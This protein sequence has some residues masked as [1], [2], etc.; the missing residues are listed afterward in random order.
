[1]KKIILIATI[2][3]S[4]LAFGQADLERVQDQSIKTATEQKCSISL[5]YIG[6]YMGW[7]PRGSVVTDVRVSHPFANSSPFVYVNCAQL[8]IVCT[9]KE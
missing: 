5:R 3:V 4:C 1:M 7:C 6:R 2:L 8:K 9:E